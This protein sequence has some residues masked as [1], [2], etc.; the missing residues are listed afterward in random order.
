RAPAGSTG[1]ASGGILYGGV[2]WSTRLPPASCEAVIHLVSPATTTVWVSPS[3]LR[4]WLRNDAG[5]PPDIQASHAGTGCVDPA[6]EPAGEPVLVTG[7]AV[8][9]GAVT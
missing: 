3:P 7:G 8:R 1:K 6:G 9:G 2:G 4:I 5:N